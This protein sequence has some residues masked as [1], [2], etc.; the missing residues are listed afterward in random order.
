MHI[1]Q[2]KSCKNQDL[3]QGLIYAVAQP[4]QNILDFSI[5]L[6]K[7]VIILNSYQVC[8]K[9]DFF[10]HEPAHAAFRNSSTDHK[11][12]MLSTKGQQLFFI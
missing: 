2:N 7:G 8:E 1:Q 9:A 10:Q 12:K 11:S 6:T 4:S 3:L 5:M